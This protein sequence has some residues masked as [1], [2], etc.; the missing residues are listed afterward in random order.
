MTA[1]KVVI[2]RKDVALEINANN[3]DEVIFDN[4]DDIKDTPSFGLTLGFPNVVNLTAAYSA[5]YFHTRI[6]G[7]I[8]PTGYAGIQGLIGY[9]IYGSKKAMIAPSVFIGATEGISNAYILTYYP[10]LDIYTET[11]DDTYSYYGVGVDLHFYGFTAF[12]GYGFELIEDV[13]GSNFIFDVGYKYS[14]Y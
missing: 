7:G 12:L 2:E 6:T 4:T 13:H 1:E 8:I 10:N 3:I 5:N 14:W 9:P 11:E